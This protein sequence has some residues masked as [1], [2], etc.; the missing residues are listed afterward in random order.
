MSRTNTYFDGSYTS[1]DREDVVQHVIRCNEQRQGVSE[2]AHGYL[3]YEH[4]NTGHCDNYEPV[5][6]RLFPQGI[7]HF[8]EYLNNCFRAFTVEQS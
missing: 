2:M 5:E 1:D 7:L 6:T 4:Y 3:H 8:D